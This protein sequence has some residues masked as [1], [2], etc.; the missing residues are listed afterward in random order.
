MILIAQLVL[1][2]ACIG[3]AV[4]LFKKFFLEKAGRGFGFP[5][6]SFKLSKRL[7]SKNLLLVRGLPAGLVPAVKQILGRV[8]VSL[9]TGYSLSQK[10]F[11][12]SK[13]RLGFLVAAAKGRLAALNIEDKL[14]KLSKKKY[15]KSF[16]EGKKDYLEKLFKAVPSK[17]A[18]EKAR[19][20]KQKAAFSKRTRESK[21][22]D[23]VF[24]ERILRKQERLILEKI[25]S[26]PK[27][28]RLYKRLGYVYLEL[29]ERRDARRCFEYALKIGRRDK[30][31]VK[32]LENL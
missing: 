22:E 24:K 16:P 19:E 4:L 27:D 30:D 2:I 11:S 28:P 31:I 29:G 20:T 21:K 6:R 13:R 8:F 26:N 12:W 3:V 1:V 9:K 15:A 25:T 32:V 17:R 23:R 18:E 14:E 5:A 10:A 7:L